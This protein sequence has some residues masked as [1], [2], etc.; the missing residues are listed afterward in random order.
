M[1]VLQLI[2]SRTPREPL[3]TLAERA[4]LHGAPWLAALPAAAR[5]DVL[6]HSRVHTV[7]A[8]ET[9]PPGPSGIALCG[10]ASGAISVRLVRPGAGIVDY[11]APGAWFLDAGALV[12][13]AS[14][15]VFR[16]HRRATVVGVSAATLHDLARRHPG[17]HLP[18]WELSHGLT[19][20]LLRSLDER[21]TCSLGIRLARCL[22]RLCET[23]GLPEREGVRLTLAV[24]QGE[25][26]VLVHASRQRLNLELKKL[27]TAGALRIGR[28][29]LV[30]DLRALHAAAD[31]RS[32][33]QA[34]TAGGIN[35]P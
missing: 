29:L 26:A 32:A 33:R 35:R 16:A 3:L 23:F 28:E 21:A 31:R 13:G 4:V 24:H 1:T 12:A 6:Q 25:L 18:L 7:R 8:N 19:C 2:D 34:P 10:L 5:H 11:L 20:R 17:L 27:E 14:S 15:L 30:T 22:L 9:V